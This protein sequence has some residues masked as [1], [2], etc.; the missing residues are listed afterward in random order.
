MGNGA[1]PVV[2]LPYRPTLTERLARSAGALPSTS[3]L[4]PGSHSHLLGTDR[5]I[6]L[7][8]EAASRRQWPPRGS[9]SRVP[10][11]RPTG[12]TVPMAGALMQSS[13]ARRRNVL[14]ST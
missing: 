6:L 10:P 3:P 12:P 11:S 2:K 1:V 14:P 13:L 8:W 7:S 5:G 4:L 9:S